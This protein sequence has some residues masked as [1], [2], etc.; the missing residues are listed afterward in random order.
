MTK[1]ASHRLF[2]ATFRGKRKK[3]ELTNELIFQAF[4]TELNEERIMLG[5]SALG[6]AAASASATAIGLVPLQLSCRGNVMRERIFRDLVSFAE[7]RDELALLQNL[8]KTPKGASIE[9]LRLYEEVVRR[10]GF[11]HV[12]QQKLWGEII[13]RECMAIDIMPYVLASYYE[14]CV[15]WLN[16]DN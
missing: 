12:C 4:V 8:P 9:W 15:C 10:G 1:S 13:A 16:G 2:S 5:T 3:C 11:E 14:W 7:S 6:M